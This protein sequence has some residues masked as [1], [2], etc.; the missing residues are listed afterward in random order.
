MAETWSLLLSCEHGGNRVPAPWRGLFAGQD[1]VLATH[2]GYDIGIAPFARRLAQAL[3]APLQLA[4][5]TRL[6]VDLNRSP[7]HPAL[8]SEFSRTLVDTERRQ[9]LEKYYLPY[10]EAVAAEVE[11]VLARGERACHI[12][13][14]SFTPQLEGQLRNADIGLLYDPRRPL[15][16]DFCRCWQ[17][18][19]VARGGHWRVRR[20]YPYRGAA[21]SL[22]NWLRRRHP[23]ERYLG[24]ELELNQRWPQ[25]GGDAWQ[26]LQLLV[27]DTLRESLDE[28]RS[29]AG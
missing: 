14:H 27:I 28:W 26:A 12:A 25:Q 10:R 16:V 15:E 6:L 8:F 18:R 2:R 13:V 17:R 5:V 3:G 9:L 20:N 23:A 24:L 11:A 29:D 1:A 4:E 19:L 7:G 22:V 21:D